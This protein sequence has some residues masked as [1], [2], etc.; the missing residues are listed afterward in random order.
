MSPEPS[1]PPVR[2]TRSHIAANV[3]RLRKAKGLSQ[4]ALGEQASF[5]RT[6]VSQLER[7][8]TNISIDRLE[9]LAVIL[10]IELVDLILQP[11]ADTEIVLKAPVK[12]SGRKTQKKARKK[13]ASA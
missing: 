13:A 9:D 8:K 5:H 10:E 7:C 11:P 1:P 4:E 12:K 3:R 2:K 6:Y